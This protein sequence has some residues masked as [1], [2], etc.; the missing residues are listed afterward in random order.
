MENLIIILIIVI[1]LLLLL[2]IDRIII[3]KMLK[4]EAEADSLDFVL[5]PPFWMRTLALIWVAIGVFIMAIA[6]RSY[7]LEFA[8]IILGFTF[9]GTKPLRKKIV[10]KGNKA[11]IHKFLRK[12]KLAFEDISEVMMDQYAHTEVIFDN[13]IAEVMKGRYFEVKCYDA[14][15]KRK[16][17]FTSDWICSFSMMQRLFDLGTLPW[18]YTKK[19]DKDRKNLIK[20]MDF[21]MEHDLT[22]WYSFSKRKAS[23]IGFKLFRDDLTD[24]GQYLFTSGAVLKWTD[25]AYHGGDVSDFSLLQEA[26]VEYDIKG[27]KE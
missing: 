16:L 8:L 11:V 4:K 5:R 17:K 13:D 9:L 18:L 10:V 26:L 24:E 3:K 12:V 6:I 19:D 1:G 27:E 22:T 2:V 14:G 21:F 15:G 25:F 7:M 23:K 20:L